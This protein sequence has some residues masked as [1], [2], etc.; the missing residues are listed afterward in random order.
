MRSGSSRLSKNEPR[1]SAEDYKRRSVAE[2]DLVNDDTEPFRSLIVLCFHASAAFCVIHSTVQ[3][4]S[5]DRK[6]R[7]E[8]DHK[9]GPRRLRCVS[10]FSSVPSRSV[11]S[12][13]ESEVRTSVLEA[14]TQVTG[15]DSLAIQGSRSNLALLESS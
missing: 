4:W 14:K 2:H 8:L 1:E 11:V 7:V 5:S 12:S 13:P 9:P 10:F 3:V 15:C 6:S